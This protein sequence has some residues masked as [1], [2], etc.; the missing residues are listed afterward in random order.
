MTPQAFQDLLD[1]HGPDTAE[2]PG[3]ERP[4]AERLLAESEP[5]RH[6]L[7]T[8]RRLEALIRARPAAVSDAAVARIMA[9]VPGITARGRSPLRTAL[10]AWG[11]MPLTP[12]L[13]FLAATLAL[14]VIAGAW[15]GGAPEPAPAAARAARLSALLYPD[16]PF[17][18]LVR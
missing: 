5:A 4:A 7:A 18:E 17:Q 15:F 11:L 9:R 8:A 6:M 2:W 16:T 10:G 13:G 3:A 12:R 1:R 14:G